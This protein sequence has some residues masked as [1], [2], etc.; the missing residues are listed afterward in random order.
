MTIVG[1]AL[2]LAAPAR[3]V[4]PSAVGDLTITEFQADPLAVPQYYGE[5]FEL[6]NTTAG[7]LDLNGLTITNSAG[8]S[9]EV[10]TATVIAAGDYLVFGVGQNRD[11]DSATFNGNVAVDVVYTLGTDASGFNLDLAAD[12]LT[13]VFDGLT[14]DIVEWTSAWPTAA[15]YAHAASLNA[16]DQEWANDFA[17]N[18]C[19]SANLIS[20]SRGMYGSAGVANEYCGDNAGS[21]NDG[22][23]WSERE[24]DCRDDDATI[25]PGALD[26]ND[27]VPESAG[28]GGDAND[29]ADCDNVRDDGVTDDDGDSYSEADGDCDDADPTRSPGAVE[30][31]DGI[32]TNCN[33]CL[34][35]IDA[36]GDSFGYSPGERCGEDCSPSLSTSDD[37]TLPIDGDPDVYP[38]APERPYDGYDQDCDGAD[39]CDVDGDTFE[40]ARCGACTDDCDCDD[41]DASVNP[42]APELEDDR[43]DNDCDGAV[44]I[45]DRDGDGVSVESGDCMDLDDPALIETSARVYPAHDGLPAATE[46]C[47]DLLDND[48]DGFYD[49]LPEC[50]NPASY[51]QVRGGGLCGVSPAAGGSGALALGALA[52]LIA[53]ARRRA[54]AVR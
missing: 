19:S 45:P 1:L 23:G 29:D 24:G 31:A 7:P 3:A 54:G 46:V 22:D 36:D 52:G 21:D 48:C 41:E 35:D 28:G 34:D 17:V 30:L 5:W 51:A 37:T 10:S 14:L 38:G 49:N 43:I 27:G 25:H 13:L 9:I 50:T 53:A 11:P 8:R 6:Y 4:A 40:D 18:W 2:L 39:L 47:G 26:G 20:E 15:N 33:G 42:G 44:D 32:D 12:S 16:F